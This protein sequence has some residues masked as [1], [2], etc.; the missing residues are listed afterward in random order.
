MEMQTRA[1]HYQPRF[2]RFLS[3]LVD[4][5][6]RKSPFTPIASK[7]IFAGATADIMSNGSNGSLDTIQNPTI[8]T[9]DLT[10][11]QRAEAL[12][13]VNGAV[14][15]IKFDLFCTRLRLKVIIF[16]LESRCALSL[17]LRKA[18]SY[19]SHGVLKVHHRLFPTKMPLPI[20]PAG[21]FKRLFGPECGINTTRCARPNLR[22]DGADDCGGGTAGPATYPTPQDGADHNGPEPQ[23]RPCAGRHAASPMGPR[24]EKASWVVCAAPRQVPL[25]PVGIGCP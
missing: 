9:L 10:P 5:L 19:F 24:L 8:G 4:I 12:K 25:S 14:R 22:Q 1:L 11:N 7:A 13:A 21:F 18:A 3:L 6:L 2:F 17:I 15:R 23:P 16:A 20:A